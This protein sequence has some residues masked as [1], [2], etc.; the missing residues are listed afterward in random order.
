MREKREEKKGN[1]K[2]LNLA[3]YKKALQVD[4]FSFATNI[5]Y[6]TI[7]HIIPHTPALQSLAS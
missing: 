5:S 3:V 4:P 6:S 2:I 1:F 7:C